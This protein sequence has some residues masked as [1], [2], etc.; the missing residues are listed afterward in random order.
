MLASPGRGLRVAHVLALLFTFACAGCASEVDDCASGTAPASCDAARPDAHDVADSGASDGGA[1]GGTDVAMDAPT[2]AAADVTTDVATGSDV[3]ATDS[4]SSDA[5]P[6]RC[7]SS[8]AADPAS[9]AA[10]GGRA[11]CDSTTQTCL[12]PP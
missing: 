4:A 7:G 12:C 10:I 3:V 5:G 8:C 2:D 6:V 1:D 9:C 11:F